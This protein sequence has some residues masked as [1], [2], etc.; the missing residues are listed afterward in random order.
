[1]STIDVVIP[2]PGGAG[3]DPFYFVGWPDPTVN[4]G[5]GV[6]FQNNGYNRGGAGA[7]AIFGA[8]I[9][10][11]SATMELWR[12]IL[13]GR[14]RATA[15]TPVCEKQA[16]LFHVRFP[17]AATG[18]ASVREPGR[19]PEHQRVFRWSFLWA[20]DSDGAP[21]R[22]TGFAV[23]PANAAVPTYP[24]AVGAGGGFGVEGDGVSGMRF[25]SVPIAGGAFQD[26]TPLVWPGPL[27]DFVLV[28]IEIQSATPSNPARLRIALNGLVVIDRNWGPGT[29]LPTPASWAPFTLSEWRLGIRAQTSGTFT[30]TYIGP[31]FV[32]QGRLTLEGEALSPFGVG[33]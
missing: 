12:E 33:I 3:R 13:V 11:G 6:A 30:H 7:F 18:A 4:F 14:L 5:P 28:D 22:G 24:S 9:G 25:F 29:L 31:M 8:T 16:E 20:M 1:M 21:L 23:M 2:S 10:T 15:G 26:L 17:M 27:A 19:F 32:T